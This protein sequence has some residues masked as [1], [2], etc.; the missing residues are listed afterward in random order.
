MKKLI[1]L[2]LILSLALAV[3]ALAEQAIQVAEINWTD[4]SEQE[5]VNAGYSG[6]WF[7]LN[8]IG[9]KL[10]IPDGYVEQELTEEDRADEYAFIFA[11]E[12]NGGKIEVFD[13]YIESCDDLA[14]LGAALREAHPERFVQY[15]M[16]NGAA[17]VLNGIEEADRVNAIFDLGDHRFVQIMF[18]PMSVE[19]QLLTACIASI[20][21]P[22]E[23]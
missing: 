12:E 4:E 20:H 11:N 3:P 19:N 9:C 5:F 18:S 14:T 13:S 6:T 8:G 15:V 2:A 7:T 22:T 1:A 21:F 17:A 23:G 16:L 10:I